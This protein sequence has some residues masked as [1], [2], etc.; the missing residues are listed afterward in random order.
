MY[1][2]ADVRGV[3]ATVVLVEESLQQRFGFS[4][5]MPSIQPKHN[6]SSTACG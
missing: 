4:S 6:A 5:V 1:D 3:G 2:E